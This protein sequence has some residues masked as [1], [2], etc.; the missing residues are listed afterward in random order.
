MFCLLEMAVSLHCR[1]TI[2]VHLTALV[3]GG[4]GS[5]GGKRDTACVFRPPLTIGK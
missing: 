1:H 5:D 2:T 3:G 4:V